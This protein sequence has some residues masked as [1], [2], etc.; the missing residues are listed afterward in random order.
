MTTELYVPLKHV[1]VTCVA[2]SF[3]L[4]FLRG[5]WH[6]RQAAVIRQPW[7]R[8]VPHIVD[9][10]LLTA[11]IGL[12]LILRQYP[13]ADGWLTAKVLALLLYIGLGMIAFRFAKDRKQ[14]FA[15]WFAALCVFAYIV[16]VALSR[17]AL[18]VL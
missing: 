7:V 3:T 13:F 6:L 17:S 9:S 1:H 4:F 12:A 14:Q 15:A 16:V 8:V 18:P 11:A 5:I 2:L 10:I